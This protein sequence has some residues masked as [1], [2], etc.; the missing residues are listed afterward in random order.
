[1]GKCVLMERGK[2]KL[3]GEN[4][5]KLREGGAGGTRWREGRIDSMQ[6]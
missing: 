3:N 6:S 1:M 4:V 2:G 5:C